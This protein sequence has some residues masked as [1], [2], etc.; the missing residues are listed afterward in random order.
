MLSGLNKTRVPTSIHCD[1][2]IVANKDA[3]TDVSDSIKENSEVYDFL[4]SAAQVRLL[5]SI[6]H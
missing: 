1:H 2:L 6:N 5:S 3:V 4:Q